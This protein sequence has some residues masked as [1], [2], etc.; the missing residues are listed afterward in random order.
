MTS[1]ISVSTFP[2]T[3]QQCVAHTTVCRSFL[4]SYRNVVNHGSLLLSYHNV[5]VCKRRGLSRSAKGGIRR[6][7]VISMVSGVQ[8]GGMKKD[9]EPEENDVQTVVI[10]GAGLAGLATALALHRYASHERIA[11]TECDFRAPNYYVDGLLISNLL[12]KLCHEEAN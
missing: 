5:S 7:N 3:R 9:S 4:A 8:L 12:D 11:I 2:I 1:S 10:V 6:G